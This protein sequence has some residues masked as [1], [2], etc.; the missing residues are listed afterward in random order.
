MQVKKI[1][2]CLFCGSKVCKDEPP[3]AGRDFYCRGCG[4][5]A[6]WANKSKKQV[7]AAWNR[8]GRKAVSREKGGETK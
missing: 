6:L 7:A 8:R 2:C 1:K 5:S 4:P 3:C